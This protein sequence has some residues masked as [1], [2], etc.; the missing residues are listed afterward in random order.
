ML[1][2]EVS[3]QPQRKSAVD[4]RPTPHN[5]E[6]YVRSAQILLQCATCI[7][8]TDSRPEAYGFHAFCDTE[9]IQLRAPAVEGMDDLRYSS[10]L[11][12]ADV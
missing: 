7:D 12:R 10:S 9:R 2:S 6:R 1:E 3:R 5:T 8:G 4:A 11:F